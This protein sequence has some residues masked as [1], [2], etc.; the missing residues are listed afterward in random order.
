MPIRIDKINIYWLTTQ[1]YRG[2]KTL[3][4]PSTSA[5]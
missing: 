5:Q 4:T 2:A 3:N 1:R